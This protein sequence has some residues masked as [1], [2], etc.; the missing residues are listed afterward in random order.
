MKSFV[1]SA[2]SNGAWSVSAVMEMRVDWALTVSCASVDCAPWARRLKSNARVLRLLVLL[3]M[4]VA[5]AV[6]SRNELSH[7]N[8]SVKV[9]LATM[10]IRWAHASRLCLGSSASRQQSPPESVNV[11]FLFIKCQQ[12]ANLEPWPKDGITCRPRF[13][14]NFLILECWLRGWLRSNLS[15]RSRKHYYR[16]TPSSHFSISHIV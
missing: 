1:P 15:K 6:A 10:V 11:Y 12:L 16:K 7:P 5:P 14:F 9:A 4:I 3:D 13:F 8:P 2:N